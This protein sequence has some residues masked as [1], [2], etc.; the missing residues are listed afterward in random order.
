[1][2]EEIDEVEEEIRKSHLETIQEKS[3]ENSM[4]ET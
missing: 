3:N 1:M 4:I 2:I